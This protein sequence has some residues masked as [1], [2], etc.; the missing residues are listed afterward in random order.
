[1]CGF[2]LVLWLRTVAYP[3]EVPG[4][5]GM[6]PQ[7]NC[8][9]STGDHLDSWI[10]INDEVFPHSFIRQIR[11]SHLIAPPARGRPTWRASFVTALVVRG[12]QNV[13]PF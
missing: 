8:L 13:V 5:D 12:M 11:H 10:M 6:M 3:E 7:L 9:S 4:R 1:M 2:H